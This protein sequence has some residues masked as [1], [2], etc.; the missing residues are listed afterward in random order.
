MLS[1]IVCVGL[2][3]YMLQLTKRNDH[4]CLFAVYPAINSV[5]F[6]G[7]LKDVRNFFTLSCFFVISGIFFG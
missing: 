2:A 6:D 5:P 7:T 4:I 3:V 1:F